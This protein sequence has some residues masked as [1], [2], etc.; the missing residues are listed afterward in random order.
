MSTPPAAPIW[1]GNVLGSRTVGTSF[2][3]G[4]LSLLIANS[5]F[6]AE[7]AG[8][9]LKKMAENYTKAKSYQASITTTQSGKTPQG[10]AFTVT[11]TE[12]ILY[13]SPNLFHKS[14]KATGSGP[15]MTSQFTE[16]LA[17]RQGEIYSDG[18]SATMYVPA[19]KMYQK[20]PVPPNVLIAQLVDLLRLV[21]GSTRPG[22]ALLPTPATVKGRRAYVIEL[23]P[24]PPPNMK[25]ED[26]KKYDE[27]LKAFKQYPRFMI[28]KQN[29]NLLEYSMV[30]STGTALVDLTSQVFGA[31]LPASAFTFTPPAGAKEFKA[32]PPGPRP[33]GAPGGAPGGPTVP[34]GKLK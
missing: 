31:P 18:K 34:G 7:N 3:I 15:A 25:P 6:A 28:D 16:Q 29:Y 8:D 21:P 13:Q 11:Q 33:G 22:L 17:T 10:K 27:G 14:V 2:A 12:H 9:I 32:P 23:K 4:A 5:A 1:A 26:K 30:T 19:K 24:V 20:Q